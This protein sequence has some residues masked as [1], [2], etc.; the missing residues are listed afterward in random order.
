MIRGAIF[1][2]DGTLLDSMSVWDSLG[3]RYL[4][5]LGL[6]PRENLADTFRTFTMEQSARYI[7]QHYGVSRSTE[8]ITAGFHRLTADFYRFEAPLRPGVPELLNRLQH[9]GVSMAVATASHRALVEAALDRCGVLPCFQFLLTCQ[10]AGS[11]TEPGIYEAARLRL[12]TPKQDTWVFEDAA[13]AAQT[14]AR[15]GFPVLGVRE[16]HEEDQQGLRACSTVYLTDFLHTEPFWR[17][18][19]H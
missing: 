4:H 3:E 9:E 13:H 2:V 1:D 14:A 19:S 15:A 17:F 12:N 11:K 7:Q 5:T 8:E 16:P 10:E 18:V 6:E